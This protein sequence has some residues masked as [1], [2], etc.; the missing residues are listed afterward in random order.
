LHQSEFWSDHGLKL[1][2][3]QLS[4]WKRYYPIF[5]LTSNKREKFEYSD[6]H[7]SA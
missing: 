7:H 3:S 4:S 5:F 6:S 2:G 1:L